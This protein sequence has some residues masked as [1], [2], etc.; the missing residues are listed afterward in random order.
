LESEEA[1]MDKGNFE[2]GSLKVY[3]RSLVLLVLDDVPSHPGALSFNNSLII[4]MFVPHCHSCK[5]THGSKCDCVNGTSTDWSS[6]SSCLF[7]Y[8]GFIE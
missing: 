5:K 2:I 1:W 8:L 7:L 4:V 3:I 6:Q